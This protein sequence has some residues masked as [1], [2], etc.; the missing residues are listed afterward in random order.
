LNG[1]EGEFSQQ[2]GCVDIVELEPALTA[3]AERR[4]A[5]SLEKTIPN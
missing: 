2:F 5:P 4:T 3:F 1:R